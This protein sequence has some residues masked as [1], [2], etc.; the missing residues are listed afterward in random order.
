MCLFS[1]GVPLCVP[2]KDPLIKSILLETVSFCFV[3]GFLGS[4]WQG[5]FSFRTKGQEESI[6][7][8]NPKGTHWCPIPP[9]AHTFPLLGLQ[10][11]QEMMNQLSLLMCSDTSHFS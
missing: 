5:D 11:D 4:L 7:T 8:G 1:S 10:V 9:I 3:S 6:S 2:L